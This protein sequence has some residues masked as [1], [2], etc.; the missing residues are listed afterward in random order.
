MLTRYM[1][2]TPESQ[3]Y[4]FTFGLALTL[5][6]MVL[7]DMWLPMVVGAIIMTGLAVESW[8]RVQHLIPIRKELRDLHHQIEQVQ[9][10]QRKQS[11]E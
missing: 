3:S 4:L 10:Q 5:L 9:K 7:T 6:G 1:G 8:I 2:M 11:E